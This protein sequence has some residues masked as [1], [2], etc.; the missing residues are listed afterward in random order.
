MVYLYLL[1]AIL[2]EVAATTFLKQT[3]GFTVLFPSVVTVVGYVCS[4]YFLSLSLSSIPLG[5]AYAVWSGIGIVAVSVLAYW[6]YHQ[7]LDA[8]AIV[9]IFMILC[10]VMVIKLFSNSL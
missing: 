10:G 9:G 2:S 7:T 5:I 8:A 4:F 6:V 1:A 3:E